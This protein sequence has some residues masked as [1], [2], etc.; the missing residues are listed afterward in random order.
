MDMSKLNTSG[1]RV[2]KGDIWH[3][4]NGPLPDSPAEWDPPMTDDEI[5]EAARSDPDNPPLTADQLARMRRISP[6]KFIRRK[7][8][9]S[10]EQFAKRFRIPLALL[11]DW[12]RHRAEP[13]EAALAYLQVIDR[14]TAAVERALE[15][16]AA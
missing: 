4:D 15:P 6:A 13:D 1:N 3:D 7:L 12:E 9:L 8:G 14:E 10:D 11:R 2:L 5:N 16:E